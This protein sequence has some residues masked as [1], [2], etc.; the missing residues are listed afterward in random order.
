MISIK[1][2]SKKYKDHQALTS[3]NIDIPKGAIYGLIGHNGAGKTSLIRIITQ[4]IKA[5]SGTVTLDGE[6]LNPDHRQLI[7]YLPEERGL[8][9]KMKIL[10][11]L[12]F[13]GNLRGLNQQE[14]LIDINYWIVKFGLKSVENQEIN[15]LS[16]G[17]Q[18]KVQFIATVFFNPQILILDEPFSGFDPSNT[19]LLKAEILA[20]NKK[21]VTII[22]STHQ[23]EAVEELCEE[24]TMIDKSKVV[25]SGKISEIKKKFKSKELFFKLSEEIKFSSEWEILKFKDAYKVILKENQSK[26]QFLSLLNMD[27]VLAFEELEPSLREVFLKQVSK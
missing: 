20:L 23:M 7:G 25:L 8:Y 14:M 5:D 11:Y 10:E 21:G 13:L 9:K 15:S 22:F 1:D 27:S 3:V 17:N 24:V 4:I 2:I 12:I 18:Q 16:K 26:K 6:V 19:E